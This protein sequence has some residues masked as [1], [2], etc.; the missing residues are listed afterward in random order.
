MEAQSGGEKVLKVT[1]DEEAVILAMRM[2]PYGEVTAE[3]KMSA[4]ISIRRNET[5]KPPSMDKQ[6]KLVKERVRSA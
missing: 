3:M 5:I 1:P 2:T 4:I 6:P